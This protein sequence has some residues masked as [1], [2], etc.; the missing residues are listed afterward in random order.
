M[1][2]D[3]AQLA[4]FVG[5]SATTWDKD[6]YIVAEQMKLNGANPKDILAKT[7][8]WWGPDGKPR[9]EI[10]DSAATAT[11][12]SGTLGKAL[13]D[14]ALYKSYP[15]IANVPA[16]V[17]TPGFFDSSV[18]GYHVPLGTPGGER[19]DVTADPDKQREVLLHEAQHAIQD[20][21]GFAP[22]GIPPGSNMLGVTHDYATYQNY[23]RIKGEAEARAAVARRDM[24]P[25][26]RRA[27]LPDQSYDVPINELTGEAGASAAPAVANPAADLRR[28][29]ED[30]SRRLM[31]EDE[32]KDTQQ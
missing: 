8:I 7:G 2:I 30:E 1:G 20:R 31:D 10:D 3:G 17:K 23:L 13:K 26:Q 12:E 5:P 22:G 32:T 24:T 15:D 25:E 9:M 6:Q 21:E 18:A 29:Y 28:Q 4:L 14:D 19:I 27:T 11:G 16:T